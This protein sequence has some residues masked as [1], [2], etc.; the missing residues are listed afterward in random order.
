MCGTICSLMSFTHPV[1]ALTGP[2]L[3]ELGS[4]CSD[5]ESTT[6]QSLQSGRSLGTLGGA[7]VVFMQIV[8]CFMG[9]RWSGKPLAPLRRDP[10]KF[11]ALACF[12]PNILPRTK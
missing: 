1:E 11:T 3:G 12:A 5:W 4:K 9:K 2:H 8:V 6:N 7:I 10:P